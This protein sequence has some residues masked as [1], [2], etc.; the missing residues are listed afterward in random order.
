MCNVTPKVQVPDKAFKAKSL[1]S[2]G[3]LG[4]NGPGP[5]QLGATR[6]VGPAW[7]QIEIFPNISTQSLSS[8]CPLGRRPPQARSP[9]RL[10]GL[11]P[12]HGVLELGV[13]LGWNKKTGSTILLSCC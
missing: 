12:S 1:V 7:P 9:S 5:A 2:A 3:L 6:N 4:Q 11:S 13:P 10:L 8:K